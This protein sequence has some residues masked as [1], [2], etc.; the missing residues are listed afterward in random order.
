M[1]FTAFLVT[2]LYL[3]KSPVLGDD[4]FP[5][6]AD[7]LEVA[8]FARDPLVRNP[9]GIAFDA[10]GRL[11]VGMGPQYRS[12]N[13]KT[14]G[15]SVYILIDENDDGF[16]DTRK[17]FATGFNSI[18]GLAWKEDVL[19][20]ANAPDFT[21]VRDTD[22]D[23]VADEYV[24]IYTDLGNLEHALHGLNWGPDGYLY[25]SKGNS[26]GLT[27]P[28][29]RVAPKA[30][31]DLW[32]VP[33]LDGVPEFPAPR[34]SGAKDYEK[35][36]H[37][38]ADD[39]GVSGGVLRCEADGSAL[40]IV[41]AGFRNPWDITFDD[42]F[43]WLGTDNDQ[44]Q[45]DKIFSPFLGAH[46]GWGH[47]WSYDWRGDNHLPSAP[48]AGPLFEGSGTGVIFCGLRNY[49]AKYRGVFLINDWL[50]R[51]VYLYR[52][53]YKGA[54]MQPT[55]TK[56]DLLVHAGG[57]RAMG[58]SHG[59]SF[60][61]VDIEI[62][63]DGAI[64]IASWGRVYGAKYK[65]GKFANEGR[66]YRIWPKATPPKTTW[67]TTRDPW[68]DLASHLPVWRANAQEILLDQ[69]HRTT[70]DGR[71]VKHGNDVLQRLRLMLKSGVTRRETA[72]ETWAT[73]TLGRARVGDSAL[74]RFFSETATSESL[75]LRIQSLRV[76]AHRARARG[77]RKLPPVVGKALSDQNAR[78]RHAA[79]LA[80]REAKAVSYGDALIARAA[81]EEDRVVAYSIWGAITEIVPT[82]TRKALL[83]D[84]RDT[85][86]RAALLGLLERDEL[87]EREIAPFTEDPNETVRGLARR[88][89]RGKAAPAIKG[90]SLT[91]GGGPAGG[92]EKAQP[93]PDPT[94][95]SVVS[96]I[97]SESGARYSE[98]TLLR[99]VRAYNDRGYLI[100]QVTEELLGETFIRSSNNDADPSS[101]TSLT[102]KLRFDSEVYVADDIRGD[103]V[104]GWIG[105]RY[106]KTDS[107]I[108]CRS[109]PV[110]CR[111]GCHR[112]RRPLSRSE[113]S[114]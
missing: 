98:A 107:W 6:V 38:P 66:I 36:Y 25:M 76:L 74:D 89:L 109:S 56:L 104:P 71:F 83:A 17:E 51:Q 30:F 63:P 108:V 105:T 61:P 111:H 69:M 39:W 110:P 82:A 87:L 102:V 73:W 3:V 42:G 80:I 60:S 55:K 67:S 21:A 93:I 54:W 28:P 77:D 35:N 24:R 13:L 15:D 34:R 46:F 11:C 23:D 53:I 64:W 95:V 14:P 112:Q 2:V 4:L 20:I 18:Q 47:P 19:Y 92:H 86:R 29:H 106:K 9:C 59:R 68:K 41:S 103:K 44:V 48:S 91:R 62:G 32:G 100:E 31:R 7:D 50:R 27:S 5:I 33:P 52:P 58:Q 101:G 97:Q 8:L 37:D 84:S 75:N 90:P 57:G 85:V 78:I 96:K 70:A 12:P 99:G 88:R 79:V 94:V 114:R 65:G 72:R 49:P 22:G 10:K 1:R 113:A 26:K 45:G 43:H 16:A 40:E 81:L